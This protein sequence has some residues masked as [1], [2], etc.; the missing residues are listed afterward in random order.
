MKPMT[1]GC[2]MGLLRTL[3]PPS[4][5]IPLRYSES[6]WPRPGARE[7]GSGGDCG[8]LETGRKALQ[9]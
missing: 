5:G 8:K 6:G 3:A 4:P 7:A 9:S 2:R 1:L